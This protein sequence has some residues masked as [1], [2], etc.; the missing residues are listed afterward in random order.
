MTWPI[1]WSKSGANY[2]VSGTNARGNPWRVAVERPQAGTR[3]VQRVLA[4]TRGGLA[5]SGDYRNFFD[6]GGRRYSHTI[7]PATGAPV[8]HATA[9]VTVLAPKAGVADALAT[10]LL[11]LGAEAGM[12]LAESEGVAAYFVVRNPDGTFATEVSPA[13][14][15][16]LLSP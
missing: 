6:H 8:T 11:A 12:R 5:T 13:F 1:T 16:A 9:S 14:A 15:E 2:G 10:A 3:A 4:L 7:D